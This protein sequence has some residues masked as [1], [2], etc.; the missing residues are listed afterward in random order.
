MIISVACDDL[1]R[2]APALELD[3]NKRGNRASVMLK[4]IDTKHCSEAKKEK[5][6]RHQ[7]GPG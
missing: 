7:V 3:T 6:T 2:K 5:E 1:R 4:R